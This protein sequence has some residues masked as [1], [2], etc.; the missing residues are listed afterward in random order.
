[1]IEGCIPKR[2]PGIRKQSRDVHPHLLRLTRAATDSNPV[3]DRPMNEFE[4]ETA[5]VPAGDGSWTTRLAGDWNIGKNSNGGYALTPVL[6]ALGVS[7]PV[8]TGGCDPSVRQPRHDRTAHHGC[9]G[10][11]S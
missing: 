5:I 3:E 8:E 7:F 2:A 6:R 11:S 4:T 9:D 1:M 10:R